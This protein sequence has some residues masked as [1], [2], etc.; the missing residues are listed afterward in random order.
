LPICW[1]DYLLFC[2]LIFWVL[3]IFSII[4]PCQWVSGIF[5]PIL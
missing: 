1:L 2:C 4:T 5:S 3:Y